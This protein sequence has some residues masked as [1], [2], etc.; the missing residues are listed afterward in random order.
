MTLAYVPRLLC[1]GMAAFS[2]VHIALGLAVSAIAR[3]ALHWAERMRPH[4][5]A[6]FLLALRLAPSTAAASI[7]IA[8]CL[9]SYLWLEP[10]TAGERVG[11]ACLAA[12]VM[13][14][15]L[16][17]AS[18]ARGLRAA[19]GSHRFLRNCR[20]AGHPARAAARIAETWIIDGAAPLLAVGGILRPR[21][22]D[23]ARRHGGALAA[24]TSRRPCATS[25]PIGL[26]TIT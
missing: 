7:V 24:T 20:R 9:P 13:G 4:R 3:P 6:W 11:F 15:A 1:I 2:L 22:V 21:L 16:W 5:A 14:A 10:H 23:L 17:C 18:L 26:R 25:T 19:A 12:A 8:V